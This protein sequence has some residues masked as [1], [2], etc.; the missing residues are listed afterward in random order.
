MADTKEVREVLDELRTGL[1]ERNSK[2][3]ETLARIDTIESAAN[4]LREKADAGEEKVTELR[5][6]IDELKTHAE[7]REKTI[8]DLQK[9]S[10]IERTQQD[11]I[12]E[13]RE[14]LRIF[15][16]MVRENLCTVAR[17]EP[18]KQYRE[19]ADVL[20]KYREQRATLEAGAVTG[21]YLLPTVLEVGQFFEALEEISD[22][23]GY[24]DFIPGLPGN[25][26]IPYLASRPTLQAARATVDTDMT[27]SD[28]T[29]GLLSL[30]PDEC[31]V[32]FPLDNRLIQMSALELGSR[33]LALCRDSVIEGLCNWVVTADGT[34]TYNSLT[35]ILNEATYTVS[36]DAGK[37]SFGDVDNAALNK[38]LAYLLKRGRARG[39]F[40][41][42]I[43]VRGILEDLNRTGKVKVLTNKQNGE[44][45]CKQRPL[46][47]DEDMP[48]EADDA[49][50]TAFM[51]VGDLATMIVG[52]V[53]GIQV[54]ASSDYL[55]G[56]NQTAFRGVINM[57]VARKPVKTLCTLKTAAA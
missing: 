10:R 33:A 37:T 8:S 23:L 27:Q 2:D 22:L 35:G 20:K 54:A 44:Y 53:G 57:D 13:K 45:L 29:F 1:E 52:L 51:A 18:P 7:E 25:V 47:I 12:Q 24:V 50:A 55:F 11:P 41:T 43:H 19:E 31:Y 3:V 36:M 16:M 32:Y 49:P 42:S 30:T 40:T 26:N 56:R 4:E 17:A 28:P 15:G 34:A 48:D 38:A 5:S 9:K 39:Q 14:A 6:E 21:S 46:V